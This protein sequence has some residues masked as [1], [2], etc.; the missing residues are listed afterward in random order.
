[1][2]SLHESSPLITIDLPM[3]VISRLVVS[4]V[5]SVS[6]SAA[7]WETA[8]GSLILRQCVRLHG[9]RGRVPGRAVGKRYREL[10]D[11]A[12]AP[13]APQKVPLFTV[14]V[15]SLGPLKRVENA[16]KSALPARLSLSNLRKIRDPKTHN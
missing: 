14:Q 5:L 10:M 7:P 15:G 8:R 1:M 9:G 11:A 2:S 12:R 3:R 6:M 16:P 4:G 13:A